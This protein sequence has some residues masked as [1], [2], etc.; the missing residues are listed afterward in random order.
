MSRPR[1]WWPAAVLSLG[2]IG[3]L[4]IGAQ[5]GLP[6]R[7]ALSLAIPVELAGLK[8]QDLEIP[9][10]EVSAAGVTSYLM[11]AYPRG[12]SVNAS[13]AYSVY[14]GYYD[15]QTQGRTIHSPKNCLPGAG[16]EALE[17]RPV[18]IA[19]PHG[20]VTVNRYLLQ[21]GNQRALVLYWYQGRGR[22]QANEYRVKWELLRDAALKRRSEEALVRV[23]VPVG[24]SE[25]TAFDAA[26]RVAAVVAPSLFTALPS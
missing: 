4:G 6:L 23:L 15:R 18:T 11:R 1:P 5:R 25:Q 19:T 8:G 12:D 16:W 21:K 3:T 9:Q 26:A 13:L 14:V 2:V 20:A 7:A 10:A 17:S 22:I 24:D